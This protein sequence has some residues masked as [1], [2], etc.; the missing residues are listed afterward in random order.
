MNLL[1]TPFYSFSFE[2]EIAISCD[3][4]DGGMC[5]RYAFLMTYFCCLIQNQVVLIKALTARVLLF[6]GN[7]YFLYTYCF[8]FKLIVVFFAVFVDIVLQCNIFVHTHCS[9]LISLRVCIPN[10]MVFLQS[11]YVNN[12]NTPNTCYLL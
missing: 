7:V 4:S 1:F 10:K 12:A 9:I 8:S 6:Y 11:R 5:S 2:H 3:F